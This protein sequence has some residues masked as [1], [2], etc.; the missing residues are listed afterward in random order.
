VQAT[1]ELV[2][3]VVGREAELSVLGELFADGPS[4]RALVVAGE[5][6]IG[7]TTIVRAGLEGVEAAGMRVFR[8]RPALGER[9]LPYVGLG[10][11]L[12]TVSPDALDVLAAPQR[13]AV[14]AALAR[15]GSSAA[16]DSSALA[17]AVLELLR[18]ES[19][20]G[21]LLLAVDDVQWLDRPTVTALT[22]A[23]RRLGPVP[24]RVLVAQRTSSG[25]PDE[26]PFGL[27]DWDDVKRL[28]VGPLSTTE[29][30]A[31]LSRRLD[32][33]LPRQRL[34]ELRH[35]S[36]GNPMFALELAR[37]SGRA[38]ATLPLALGERLRALD[39]GR[40]RAL[41]F[42][43]ASLLPSIDLLLAAG[44]RREELAGAV[45]SGIVEVEDERLSFAHPLLGAAA[46]EL[47]LPDERREIHARLA[48]ASTDPVERGHHVSRSAVGRDETAAGVLDRAAA[49]ARSLG[50]H[51]GAA[52]FLL[53]AADLSPNAAA[54]QE[55]RLRA[56]IELELAGDVDRAAGLARDLIAC[57]PPGV[58]RARARRLL[59]DCSLGSEMSYDEGMQELALAI[60][61]AEGDD[62]MQAELHV[63]MLGIS[64]GMCR[65]EQS[66]AHGRRA[67]ELAE[68]A[69]ANAVAV[70]ALAELGFALCMLGEGVTEEARSAVE[71]WDGELGEF[72]SPN[73]YPPRLALALVLLHTTAFDEAEHLLEVELATAVER[74]LE[75]IEVMARSHLPE[76]QVRAGRWADALATARLSVEHARQAMNAQSVCGASYALAMT[77]ALLGA[78]AEA[79]AIASASL[80]DAE[81]T[82]DF[83]F[84]VSHRAVLG[85]IALAEDDCQSAVDVLEAA[86]RLMLEHGLGDLSIFPVAQVLGEAL[87]AVGRLDEA[88]EVAETLR[89]CPV[90]ERPWCRAMAARL[91]TFVASAQGDHAS[92]RRLIGAA[93]E[94]HAELPEPFEHARTLHVSGRIERSARNWGAARAALTQALERYDALGAARWAEKAAGD[95]ARLPGRRPADKGELTTREREVAEF[96]AA[97]LSNKEVA[98]RLFISV[99]TVEA[100]LSKVYAKLGIRSRTELASRLNRAGEA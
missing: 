41:Y 51:A 35:A 25:L 23:L 96:V 99:R 66:V 43:A 65:L 1:T 73:C 69:G 78:H 79:R 86:W 62:A 22:F 42:A 77:E 80:A 97:G 39:A 71:R 38:A 31:V 75:P 57:L 54:A 63:V 47:L 56:S 55:R 89:S 59:A 30:G 14:E 7:K 44:V 12:A 48:A 17:R 100:N 15:E 28:T 26:L 32:R 4:Q 53:R 98:T 76:V 88:V 72:V 91:E 36:A 21:D 45:E 84:R 46:Y 24:L 61:D 52:S 81:A 49:E 2:A 74:G 27:A 93:L 33:Q 82:R 34:E 87:V 18:M 94:A 29:L 40:R 20:Q 68:R 95:L 64:W 10:D 92:A 83:W 70:A 67:V 37:V 8:A 50:D 85:L 90:G 6:G 9:E 3:D 60:A 11:L 16:V 19:A 58:G 5:P 13:A